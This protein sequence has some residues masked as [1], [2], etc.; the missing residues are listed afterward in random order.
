[1]TK[2]SPEYWKER[3]DAAIRNNLCTACMKSPPTSGRLCQPCRDAYT[4]KRNAGYRNVAKAGRKRRQES[5]VKQGICI[6]CSTRKSRPRD[7][8]CLP[9]RNRKRESEL[10]CQQK[11][12]ETRREAGLCILCGKPPLA[13]YEACGR[14]GKKEAREKIR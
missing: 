13:G 1:M 8:F 3:R 11:K 5:L 4:A 10:R 2:R 6:R 12:R 9:C 14:H 7:I